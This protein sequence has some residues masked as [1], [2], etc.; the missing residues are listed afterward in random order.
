MYIRLSPERPSARSWYSR[1]ALSTASALATKLAGK[2]LCTNKK[3]GSLARPRLALGMG[4]KALMLGRAALPMAA[5]SKPSTQAYERSVL[6]A[7]NWVLLGLSGL[8]CMPMEPALAS[9]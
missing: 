6:A 1:F 4:T 2:I 7:R 3:R 8:S 9:S 5:S